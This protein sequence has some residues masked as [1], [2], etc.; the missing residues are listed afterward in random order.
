[1]N[2]IRELVDRVK[3]ARKDA[4]ARE[5]AERLA[6]QETVRLELSTLERFARLTEAVEESRRAFQVVVSR[7]EEA[8]RPYSLQM[9]ATELTD[10]FSRLPRVVNSL[11]S[12]QCLAK[13]KAALL[14]EMKQMIIG[15]AELELRS[16]QE[17]NS[18]LLQ[19]HGVIS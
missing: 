6:A 17:A 2:P 10:D 9:A 19:K 14:A 1:M 4:A 5:E 13:H 18:A 11:A 3:G 8:S 15:Q 7:M 12:S 16:F